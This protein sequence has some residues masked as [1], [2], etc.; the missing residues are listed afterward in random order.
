MRS[1]KGQKVRLENG[2]WVV[3]IS[4]D[5]RTGS[6]FAR[7]LQE[8]EASFPT[9][10]AFEP[11]K[12]DKTWPNLLWVDNILFSTQT[13]QKWIMKDQDGPERDEKH[14]SGRVHIYPASL[15]E[16]SR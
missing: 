9:L 13:T 5:G 7:F 16:R 2:I 3:V 12:I 14:N 6:F 8:Q 11:L 4:R 10:G 15:S 1:F